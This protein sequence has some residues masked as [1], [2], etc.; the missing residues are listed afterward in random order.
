VEHSGAR[1]SSVTDIGDDIVG[2]IRDTTGETW[3]EIMTGTCA[4][5]EVLRN[6]VLPGKSEKISAFNNY[7]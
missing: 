1:A 3:T 2:K 6:V 7:I 4:L 5:G